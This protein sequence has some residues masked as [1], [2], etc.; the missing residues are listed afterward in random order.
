MFVNPTGNAFR[1]HQ[2]YRNCIPS[3]KY[4]LAGAVASSA[5]RSK[6]FTVFHKRYSLSKVNATATHIAIQA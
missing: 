4:G 5:V 3:S 1:C 6:R 2:D